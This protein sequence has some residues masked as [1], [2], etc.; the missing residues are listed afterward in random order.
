MGLTYHFTFSAP[1]TVTADELLKFLRK[2]E[3]DA[4]KMGFKPTT[5]LEAAFDTP[6]RREFARRLT[7][8]H[9]LESE[10]LKGVVVLREGQV[11]SHNPVHGDCRVIPERG[12][13]LVMTDE[14]GCETVF[15]FLKY[16]G[17]LKD[18]NGRDAVPTGIGDR[19]I[20]RDFVD[21]PDVRFR[22][23]VKQFVDAGYVE[24]ERD[25]FIAA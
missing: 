10:K 23:I 20:F 21:S 4:K 15:G 3:K 12:V 7:S 8:G 6:E 1:A 19:W 13:V 5:V 24:A 16:P 25:E 2:V 9:R 14:R 22:K 18:L 11:W 17:A